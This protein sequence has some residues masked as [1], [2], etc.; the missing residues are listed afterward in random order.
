MKLIASV[1]LVAR[2]KV[3]ESVYQLD[4]VTRSIPLH[5]ADREASSSDREGMQRLQLAESVLGF[6]SVAI[7]QVTYADGSIWKPES[8]HVCG[9][10]S[11]GGSMRVAK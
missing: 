8:A 5:L 2:V 11:P 3:K 10:R 9:Y 4:S 1:D 7:Q 6:E